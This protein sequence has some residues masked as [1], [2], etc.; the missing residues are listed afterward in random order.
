MNTVVLYLQSLLNMLRKL[1]Q[2]N[3][4]IRMSG[5]H[6]SNIVCQ[7]LIIAVAI[8]HIVISSSSELNVE[9]SAA[10]GFNWAST[11]GRVRK[12][13]RTGNNAQIIHVDLVINLVSTSSHAS[14]GGDVKSVGNIGIDQKQ[15]VQVVGGS[16]VDCSNNITA[17]ILLLDLAADVAVS[18][19]ILIS[20]TVSITTSTACDIGEM[21][22][23]VQ[24]LK[25]TQTELVVVT[26]SVHKYVHTVTH[27]TH[28]S[29]ERLRG[30]QSHQ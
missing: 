23:V 18:V 19:S 25:I 4:R 28:V 14:P 6:S 15:V 13:D 11:Y 1:I 30:H 24:R 9:N 7:V 21:I 3:A 17:T 8:D 5:V 26:V 22:Q 27:S 2:I 16:N 12:C 29:G 10:S 20:R